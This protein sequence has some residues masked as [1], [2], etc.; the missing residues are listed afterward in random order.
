MVGERLP[1]PSE[2]NDT[3]VIGAAIVATVGAV[4]FAV[5]LLAGASTAVYGSALAVGL[6]S[7][8]IGVR[9][10][11]AAAYPDLEGLEPREIPEAEHARTEDGAEPVTEVAPAA[12][13]NAC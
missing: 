13:C 8:A 4:V 5:G 3:I 11:F 10:Y 9:R 12:C 2:V 6:L 1:P 7:L